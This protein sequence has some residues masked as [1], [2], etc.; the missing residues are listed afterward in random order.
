MSESDD[1]KTFPSSK[2]SS[3]Q[4]GPYVWKINAI[5]P[6][7]KLIN[8]YRIGVERLAGST[9][10]PSNCRA[11]MIGVLMNRER[12]LAET[13]FECR[14]I[15]TMIRGSISAETRFEFVLEKLLWFRKELR[16]RKSWLCLELTSI[17]EWEFWDWEVFV[18]FKRTEEIYHGKSEKNLDVKGRRVTLRVSGGSGTVSGN[19]KLWL[20][21][22][23]LYPVRSRHQSRNQLFWTNSQIENAARLVKLEFVSLQNLLW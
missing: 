2:W 1:K 13:R 10:T 11:G 15:I 12:I 18:R 22:E 21:T 23:C 17:W 16:L 19:W 3:G 5:W 8:V 6:K 7:E 14:G 4:L 20:S 9:T